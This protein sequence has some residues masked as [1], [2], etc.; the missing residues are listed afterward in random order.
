M[1]YRGPER[2]GL[3][4][5]ASADRVRLGDIDDEDL[6]REGFPGM[7]PE[8]FVKLYCAPRNPE[9]DRIVTRIVLGAAE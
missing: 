8:D 7:R 3:R 5:I 9:P 1:N 2:L 4:R 6:I